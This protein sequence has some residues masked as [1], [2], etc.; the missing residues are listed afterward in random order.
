MISDREER[1]IGEVVRKVA[2]S[3]EAYRVLPDGTWLA[4]GCGIFAR[5]IQKAVRSV[6]GVEASL[7]ALRGGKQGMVQHVL[8]RIGDHYYDAEGR[9]GEEELLFRWEYLELIEDSRVEPLGSWPEYIMQKEI[10]SRFIAELL[11]ER[12]LE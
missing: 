10:A 5:A 9:S 8:V 1:K 11:V 3:D 12:L 7:Y 4:G 6:Y 2:E